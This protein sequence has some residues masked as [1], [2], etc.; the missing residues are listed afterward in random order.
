MKNKTI[1]NPDDWKHFKLFN[2]IVAKKLTYKEWLKIKNLTLFE[3]TNIKI[4]TINQ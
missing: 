3:I 4:K 2:T 1:P